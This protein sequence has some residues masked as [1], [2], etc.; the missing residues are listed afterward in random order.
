[1]RE[2]VDHLK[3]YDFIKGM[4]ISVGDANAGRGQVGSAVYLAQINIKTTEKY[5]RKESIYDLQ[6]ILRKE[7]AYLDN[8]RVTLSIPATFGGSGAEINCVLNGPDLAVLEVW[9]M[10]MLKKISLVQD[11]LNF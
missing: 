6:A 8:C 1:M 9:V 10:F 2:A 3:K 4:T 11:G 7:L 5:E